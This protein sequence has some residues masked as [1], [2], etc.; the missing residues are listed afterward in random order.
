MNIRKPYFAA[1]LALSF[2]LGGCAS[3]SGGDGITQ[4]A[5]SVFSGAMSAMSNAVKPKESG[6]EITDEQIAQIKEGMT[7]DQ[8]RAQLGDS[9]EVV[10]VNGKEIWR[11]QFE[12]VFGATQRYQTT[13]VRFDRDGNVVRAFREK[14]VKKGKMDHMNRF[15]P[16]VSGERITPEKMAMLDTN[17]SYS[18]VEGVLGLPTEVKQIGDGQAWFY[19]F[20]EAPT[21]GINVNE[22][23]VIRFDS[24]G[25]VQDTSTIEGR[26][27]MKYVMNRIESLN[28]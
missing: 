22:T 16:L 10:Q 12:S 9:P 28:S 27:D 5:G 24:E 14:S 23:R 20:L 3:Q 26:T 1:A 4:G 15:D 7:A 8:V 19:H 21:W 25:R 2:V 6:T 17:M 18:D 11:Y 13:T